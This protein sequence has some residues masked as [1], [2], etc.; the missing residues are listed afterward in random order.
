LRYS[1]EGYCAEENIDKLLRY[2]PAIK[3]EISPKQRPVNILRLRRVYDKPLN[4]YWFKS[5]KK[6]KTWVKVKLTVEV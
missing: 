5:K 6:I 1:V 3:Y 2:M 4:N